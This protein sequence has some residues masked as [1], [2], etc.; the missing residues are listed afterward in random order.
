MTEKHRLS[1][2]QLESLTSPIRLA[3]IQRLDIDKEAT[4]HELAQRMGR[5]VTSLYHHLKQLLE[6]GLLRVSGERK[7]SRRPEAV[8]A[9][10]GR[11]SSA[12]A[13]KSARGRKAYARAGIRIADAGARAF[14]A[15]LAHGK[16]RFDGE[17]RN[18][19]AK[20]Y[21]LRA[22][23]KKLEELNELLAKLGEVAARSSEDGEEI[24]LTILLSPLNPKP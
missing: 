19:A 9:N 5:P 13:I 7:G 18:T 17:N 12:D 10:V 11:L 23:R 4:A 6:V 1:H 15:T 22:D 3:I 14:S 16:A 24:R 21:V 8:Y 2:R 20:H